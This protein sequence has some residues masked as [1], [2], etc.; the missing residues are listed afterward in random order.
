M[1]G[2]PARALAVFGLSIVIGCSLVSPPGDYFDENGE[3]VTLSSVSGTVTSMALTEDAVYFVTG[4]EVYR[5]SKTGGNAM[6][7]NGGSKEA[8]KTMASDGKELVVWCSEGEGVTYV[9]EG[10]GPAV[11]PD[12]TRCSGVAASSGKIAYYRAKEADGGGPNSVWIYDLATKTGK[13]RK[14]TSLGDEGR[15]ALSADGTVYIST[16]RGIARPCKTSTEA[17]CYGDDICLVSTRFNRE[18]DRIFV[19]PAEGTM[20]RVVATTADAVRRIEQTECC[21]KPKNDEERPVDCP[22]SYPGFAA[23]PSTAVLFGGF[24]YQLK[25]GELIRRRYDAM[26]SAGDVIRSG[27]GAS[28]RHLALDERAAYF[29]DGQRVQRYVPGCALAVLSNGRCP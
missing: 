1:N 24:V 25:E 27:L 8:V 17:N 22:A 4:S 2:L 3:I 20:P 15:L 9:R 7:L 28:L 26:Q 16:N 10:S 18:P 23:V 29:V 6:R 21:P 11:V 19:E 13:E 12:S 5:V 14:A